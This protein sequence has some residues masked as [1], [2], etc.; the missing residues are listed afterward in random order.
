MNHEWHFVLHSSLRDMQRLTMRLK[1]I[2]ILDT[3]TKWTIVKTSKTVFGVLCD[4]FNYDQNCRKSPILTRKRC[5]YCPKTKHEPQQIPPRQN[6]LYACDYPQLKKCWAAQ[7]RKSNVMVVAVVKRMLLTR[8]LLKFVWGISCSFFDIEF[9]VNYDVDVLGSWASSQ[10]IS[11]GS[12]MNSK[13][14]LRQVRTYTSPCRSAKTT[15]IITT[16][17][18]NF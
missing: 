14:Q 13:R 15:I 11:I 10:Q 9:D 2:Y 1:R 3:N 8:V 6:A 4:N 5:C 7:Q 18:S 12:V 16:R 17:V